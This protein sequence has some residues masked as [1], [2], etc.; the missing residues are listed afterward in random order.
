MN[1][2]GNLIRSVFRIIIAGLVLMAITGILLYYLNRPATPPVLT[3][4]PWVI[5]T[6]SNDQHRIPSRFYFVS[7]VT[8]LEDGTPQAT[9]WWSFDGKNYEKHDGVK[10]FPKS[11]YGNI[12]IKRRKE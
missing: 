7:K 2:V 1:T 8:I 11:V 10:L 9:D 6:F 3:D 5:Q 12:D 4:A